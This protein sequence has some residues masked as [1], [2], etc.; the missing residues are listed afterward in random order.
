VLLNGLDSITGTRG[1]EPASRRQQRRN[2][3]T[4]EINGEEKEIGKEGGEHN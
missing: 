4:I 2:A 1:R 3:G